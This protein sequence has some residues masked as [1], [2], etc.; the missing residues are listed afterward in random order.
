MNK[1]ERALHRT[2]K[3]VNQVCRELDIDSEDA[4]VFEIDQCSS[5]SIWVKFE[6]LRE[7]LDGNP[8]CRNCWDTYG[9]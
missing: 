8:I 1:L 6:T 4:E 3:T 2:R 9:P 5:C 7:D